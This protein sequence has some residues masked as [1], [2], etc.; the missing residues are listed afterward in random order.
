MVLAYHIIFTGYGFWLPNDPRGSWSDFVWAWELACYGSATKTDTRRSV[1]GAQH[2]H[3]LRQAAKTALKYPP[4]QFNGIQARAIGRGFHDARDAG[5]YQI[6][7]CSILP[8]H[9]HM[10]IGRHP[11]RTIETIANHLK[12]RATTFLTDDGL[13][14]FQNEIARRGRRPSPWSESFWQVYLDSEHD[15]ERAIRYVENNP[16]K[17]GLRPQNW[18]FVEKSR[19]APAFG[20]GSAPQLTPRPK[21]RG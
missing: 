17:D 14:P 13:H 3:A 12:A 11:E 5:Q 20:P 21:G 19:L 7:A 8:E 6:L 9:V 4:V 18:R 10:V 2:D 15:I 1:A 16:L